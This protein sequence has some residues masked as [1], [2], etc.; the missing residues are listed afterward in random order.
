MHKGLHLGKKA[1]AGF[2]CKETAPTQGPMGQKCTGVATG[3][4]FDLFFSS[5][6]IIFVGDTKNVACPSF[7][8]VRLGNRNRATGGQKLFLQ[9][10]QL[11]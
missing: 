11:S 9:I 6:K 8:S 1:I 3:T 5:R 10:S 7:V 2:E 4:E